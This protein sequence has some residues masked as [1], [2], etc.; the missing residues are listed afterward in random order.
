MRECVTALISGLI[1]L[2]L[3][4]K[5]L[6]KKWGKTQFFKSLLLTGNYKVLNER[7]QYQNAE[8][9]KCPVEFM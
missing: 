9:L 1:D 6:V 3:S 8:V 4:S 5:L 2:R 7:I